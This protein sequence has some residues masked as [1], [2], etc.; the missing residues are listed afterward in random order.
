MEEK[1]KQ[2]KP[3]TEFMTDLAKM[4]IL[5]D[6]TTGSRGSLGEPNRSFGG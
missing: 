3:R 4:C 5:S 6:Q 2:K 1:A